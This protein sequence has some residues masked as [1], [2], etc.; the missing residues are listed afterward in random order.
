MAFSAGSRGTRGE[1]LSRD[2]QRHDAI[3]DKAGFFRARQEQDGQGYGPAGETNSRPDSR[4]PDKPPAVE[5]S[6]PRAFRR[7]RA[8]GRGQNY[9]RKREG[10][11]GFQAEGILA[12]KIG[13]A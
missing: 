10:N 2:F 11:P 8:I 6:R 12:Y 5:K 1:A 13:R 4:L 7:A 3:G 9:R